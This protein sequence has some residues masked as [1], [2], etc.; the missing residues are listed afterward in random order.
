MKY[1]QAMLAVAGL[2]IVSG[3]IE[4]VRAEENKGVTLYTPVNIGDFQRCM[5]VNVSDTTL[6][7]TIE[8]IDPQ[9]QALSCDSPNTCTD[10]SGTLTTT[11]PTP[12]FQIL[13]GTGNAL[14]VTLPPGTV[15]NSYCAVAVSGTDNRDDVRV[16]LVTNITRT[17]PGTTIPV[18]L[19]RVVEGH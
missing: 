16:S 1:I 10:K 15:K 3:M 18:L 11:N 5:A 14:S 9:G 19:T 6:G 4:S 12:E 8:L 2:L 17:I 13:P 7:I